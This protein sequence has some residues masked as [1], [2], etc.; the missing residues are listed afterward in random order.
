MTNNKAYENILGGSCWWLAPGG[1]GEPLTESNLCHDQQTP[2]ALSP[3][4][5]R[6]QHSSTSILSSLSLSLIQ[7]TVPFTA[8]TYSTRSAL[9]AAL[10]PSSQTRLQLPSIIALKLSQ[11]CNVTPDQRRLLDAS[12]LIVAPP[13]ETSPAGDHPH[14]RRSPNPT[15]DL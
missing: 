7:S 8:T 11:S 4:T 5:L 1:V 14:R 6:V 9:P 10:C 15:T 3:L 2:L 12:L 13:F